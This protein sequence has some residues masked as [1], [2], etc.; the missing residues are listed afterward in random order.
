[1]LR[2]PV[3]PFEKDL[4]ANI[5][6]II[7]EVINKLDPIGLLAMDV[8]KNEYGPEIRTI[9]FRLYEANGSFLKLAEIM[10]VVFAYMYD[11]DDAKPESKYFHA[12]NEVMEKYK[13]WKSGRT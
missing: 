6:P 7:T 11:L 12:A 2:E 13:E 9:T 1:M 5:E 3:T 10:Y 8:P 4:V